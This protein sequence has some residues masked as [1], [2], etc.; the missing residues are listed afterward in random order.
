VLSLAYFLNPFHGNSLGFLRRSFADLL[1]G[2]EDSRHASSGETAGG[3]F[4]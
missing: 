4:D 2:A 3:L 1:R